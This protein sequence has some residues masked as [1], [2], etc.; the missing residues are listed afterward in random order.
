MDVT[1]D[2]QNIDKVFSSTTYF[3]D[4]YQRQYKWTDEP[5]RRLLDDIFYKFN[6]EYQ[7]YKDSDI[8][9][10]KL[11][12]RYSWYY[13][14][15]YV[16]NNID[17]KIYVVDGQQRLTTLT[18]VLIKLMH[19]ANEANS[20]L[21]DW[22]AGKIA[23]QSGFKKE[24]WMNHEQHKVS[25]SGL[26]TGKKLEEIDTSSGITAFNMVNNY[27][28]ISTVL[29]KELLDKHKLE[30][31]IFYFLK[32]LVLINLNVEQTDVPMVFEVIND[33]GVKLKPYEILKGKLLGQIDKDELDQLGLNEIWDTQVNVINQYNDDEIDVFFISFLRSKFAKTVGDTRKFDRNYHRAIFLPEVDKELKLQHSPKDVKRFLLNEFRYYSELYYKILSYYDKPQNDYLSVYYNG[34]TE[35]DSQFQLIMSACVINDSQEQEKIKLI[36]REVDRLFSLL[37]LQKSYDSND[38]NEATYLIS[39]EIRG[40]DIAIIKSVFDKYLLKMLSD[41]RGVQTIKPISYSYFKDTGIELNKRFK[42]YF[43]ARIEQFIADQTKMNMKHSFYDLVANTGSVNGFHIE[44]ILANNTENLTAFGDEVERFERERNRLGGLLLLKGKDNISS[45]NELYLNKLKTYANTLYWN[46]TLR[47]DSYKTKIDF[48]NMMKSFNLKFTPM[49]Q[50]GPN[51]LEERHMLLY[52]LIC[53][54]WA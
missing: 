31:F 30:T 52:D 24:F 42:R 4:F 35:M 32:R 43:F 40:Q 45:S 28:V 22:L 36:S 41:A 50:Y 49:D 47:Q 25:M 44:H 6:V 34:L 2:K 5:V 37:Q 21:A 13:L 20:E 3:I 1:P 18:L 15:T 10:D 54:I 46:E 38:F 29:D 12:E 53:I 26:F 17:G 9:L 48:S 39:A 33:R 16:T 19:S 27:K 51:E 23:G 11:V 7:R 14:N 8:E